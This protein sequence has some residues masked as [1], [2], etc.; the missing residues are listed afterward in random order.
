[1]SERVRGGFPDIASAGTEQTY[2]AQ[3]DKDYA[4]IV[5]IQSYP[6]FDTDGALEGPENDAL[7]FRDWVISPTGGN[8]PDDKEHVTLIISADYKPP[9]ATPDDARPMIMDVQG[10]FERLQNKAEENANNDQGLQVG[11]R[12]YIYMAGHGFAPREDQTAL[13]MANAKRNRTGAVYHILGQYTADWFFKAKYFEEVILLMDCCRELYPVMGLNMSFNPS[14]APGAVDK[15]KRFYGYATKWSRLSREKNIDGV[16]RGIFTATLMKALEG[17]AVDPDTGELTAQS[18]SDYLYTNMESLLDEAEKK[19]ND[20]Q[21]EPEIDYYPKKG[22]GFVLMTVTPPTFRVTIRVPPAAVGKTAQ[23]LDGINLA[24][25][26]TANAVTDPWVVDLKRGKYLALV[27]D[28]GLKKV[29]EVGGTGD[30]N[31][32]L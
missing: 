5:G 30:V 18:L 3:N 17:G 1:M 11:R 8:V 20:I 23:I 28:A 26:E 24:P 7:A 4:I 25:V 21:K 31:E 12:L 32:S 29:I 15:V 2:M 6:D 19:R 14:L 27:L 16:R 13:L 22:K 9:A 10:A